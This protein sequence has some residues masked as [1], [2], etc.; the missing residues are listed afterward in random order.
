MQNYQRGFTLVE[1]I[2][3]I[4]ILAI[5][6]G[7]FL[8]IL[9]PIYQYN[10][11]L[12]TQ[13]LNDL[14][15]ITTSL[16]AYY[17]DNNSYPVELHF[18]QPWTGYMAKV[19]NDPQYMTNGSYCYI[20]DT[21]SSPQWNVLF[22]KL[23]NPQSTSSCPLSTNCLPS[24]F[25]K[26]WTCKIS[27]NIDCNAVKESTL[28]CNS[29]YLTPIPML[30][31][32]PTP[33]IVIYAYAHDGSSCEY[34]PA[35]IP[36]FNNSNS[37]C[38]D[39]TG[40]D[41][42]ISGINSCSQNS[43]NR[44]YC[45]YSVFA[46]GIGQS[47]ESVKCIKGTQSC[48]YLPS[49]GFNSTTCSNNA[50]TVI[51]PKTTIPPSIHFTYPLPNATVPYAKS[52]QFTLHVD[53]AYDSLYGANVYINGYQAPCLP[54]GNA[55]DYTCKWIDGSEDPFPNRQPFV[56]AVIMDNSGNLGYAEMH[57]QYQ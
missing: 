34:T 50:C 13:R 11:A 48:S 27:G 41:S 24:G 33:P 46:Y 18:G 40:F 1:V 36:G 28:P 55:T 43:I 6:L 31:P 30:T 54:L 9:N 23:V 14:T 20:T 26:Q 7:S 25:T 52:I 8:R 56:Q 15:I 4:T 22:S 49:Y 37:Y 12:D 29:S 51:N 32:T 47:K 10:K 57:L 2:V 16:D 38:K 53:K 44:Y 39:S 3:S 35:V 5:L 42:R 19:P 21:S 45:S 17:N